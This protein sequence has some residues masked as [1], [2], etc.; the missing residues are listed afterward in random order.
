MVAI[1][2]QNLTEFWNVCT[3]SSD[4]KGLGLTPSET[5]KPVSKLETLL[6]VLPEVPDIYAEWRCLVATHSVS[7]SVS[8]M[9]G[10]SRP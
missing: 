5:D 1:V 4:R 2:P 6:A 9:R 10:W 3:R 8:I 7:G